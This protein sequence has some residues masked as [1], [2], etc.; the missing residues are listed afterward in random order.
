MPSRE[1]G[2][3][4]GPAARDVT[5][6]VTAVI[7]TRTFTYNAALQEAT[8]CIP[9]MLARK[10][11]RN[12]AI[13]RPTQEPACDDGRLLTVGGGGACRAEAAI[14]L[15]AEQTLA[16]VGGASAR[17]PEL[18]TIASRGGSGRCS[19]A[20]A[21]WRRDGGPSEWHELDLDGQ[22]GGDSI[23]SQALL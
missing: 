17:R 8:E 4:K 15:L 6:G 7:G 16:S 1:W 13:A 14:W 2:Q 18:S 5:A 9:C 3:G 23:F 20:E 12:T 19:P 10:I 21:Q 22:P 11:T